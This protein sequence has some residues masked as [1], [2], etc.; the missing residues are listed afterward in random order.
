MQAAKARELRKEW[1][2][3]PCDHP[4]VDKEYYLGAQTGDY[5]CT[6]CG[7]EFSRGDYEGVTEN[8]KPSQKS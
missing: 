5:V 2:D 4:D 1:G 8:R 3:K 6:Q 7:K